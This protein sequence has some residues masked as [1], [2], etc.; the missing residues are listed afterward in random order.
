[1]GEQVPFA[2]YSFVHAQ[3]ISPTEL[4]LYKKHPKYTAVALGIAGGMVFT[5]VAVA[6][7][8][9]VGL[10]TAGFAAGHPGFASHQKIQ[11]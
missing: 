11:C 6:A 8:S 4:P 7:M 9:Y 10:T 2:L 3:N 1:M 5:P